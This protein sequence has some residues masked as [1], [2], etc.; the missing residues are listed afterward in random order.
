LGDQSRRLVQR[1]LEREGVRKFTQ[2]VGVNM[3]QC[4]P[5]TATPG[6][7]RIADIAR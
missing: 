6:S 7:V 4:A 1:G 2:P 3:S 5:P